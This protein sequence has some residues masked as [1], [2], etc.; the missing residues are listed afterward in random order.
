[1]KAGI[2][3]AP[4]VT[5]SMTRSWAGLASSRFGPT[6]P[7]GGGSGER[8]AAAAARRREHRLA[9][10]RV[11]FG[12]SRRSRSVSVVVRRLSCSPVAVPCVS[13][14][15]APPPLLGEEDDARHRPHEEHGGHEHEEAEPV[16]GEVRVAAREVARQEREEDQQARE[17]AEPELPLGGDASSTGRNLPGLHAV[18]RRHRQAVVLELLPVQLGPLLVPR[19][20]RR[21]RSRGSGWRSSCPGRTP[22]RGARTSANATPSK[23]LWSSFSTITCQG[24]SRPPPGSPARGLRTGVTVAAPI[25][26]DGSNAR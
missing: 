10:C 7:D 8:V 16:A 11:P 21:G 15:A 9:R 6:V 24:A 2:A 4:F 19:P 5:R 12:L 20:G 23:V 22:L 25:G 14:A 26:R 18:E 3:P 13:V 17:D 1:M